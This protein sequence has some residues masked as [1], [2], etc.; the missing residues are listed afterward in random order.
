MTHPIR[1][2]ECHKMNTNM[3]PTK[4]VWSPNSKQHPKGTR[5][6]PKIGTLHPGGNQQIPKA[7]EMPLT[8]TQAIPNRVVH[9]LSV[10]H[11]GEDQ[12]SGHQQA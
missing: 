1:W 12:W 5:D 2:K 6:S 8:A 3:V 9:P 11:H 10:C 4:L 7:K